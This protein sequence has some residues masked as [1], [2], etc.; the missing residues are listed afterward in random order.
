MTDPSTSICPECGASLAAG[1]SCRD[2]FHDLLALEWQV[3]GAPSGAPHFFAVGSYNLQ[4][5]SGFMPAALTGL[6]HTIVDV[7][8]GRAT[9]ADALQRARRAADGS[10][11]VRRR[12]DAKLSEAER[13]MLEHW[14][15][16][17]PLTV[18]DVSE[19]AAVQYVD[20]VTAWAASTVEHLS[21]CL[22]SLKH[23]R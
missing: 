2:Y 12:G 16:R 19:V 22:T 9:V 10:T 11:R 15:A 5:P 8:A 3:P 14:P 20:R 23:G 21:T 18:R 7:L 13:R 1:R 17:W 6:H 4:H